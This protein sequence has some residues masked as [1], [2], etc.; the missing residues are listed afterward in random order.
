VVGAQAGSV[1]VSVGRVGALSGFRFCGWVGILGGL[2]WLVGSS[3]LL[4]LL[5]DSLLSWLLVLVASFFL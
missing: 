3:G 4:F 2:C 5:F 1:A